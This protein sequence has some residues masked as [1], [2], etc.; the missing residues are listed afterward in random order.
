MNAIANAPIY[1]GSHVASLLGFGF[2]KAY[3]PLSAFHP[4]R[5][6]ATSPSSTQAG[7]S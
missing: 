5:A 3:S 2:D 1:D 7:A 6:K 4:W